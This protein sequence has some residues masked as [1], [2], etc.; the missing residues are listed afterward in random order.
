MS[1]LGKRQ[2]TAPRNVR[3]SDPDW[4]LIGRAA[5]QLA[6]QLRLPVSAADFVRLASVERAE[7]LIKTKSA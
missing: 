3:F 2:E 5:D 6:G 1:K 4:A 7:Q